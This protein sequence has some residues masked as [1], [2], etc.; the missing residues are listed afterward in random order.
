MEMNRDTRYVATWIVCFAVLLAALAPFIS[1][2]LSATK[3]ADDLWVQVC[4]VKGSRLIKVE[5]EQSS[6]SSAPAKSIPTE[7]CPFC[8]THAGAVGLPP[9]A[10]F[11]LPLLNGTPMRPVLYYQSPRPLFVW[12]APQSRAPPSLS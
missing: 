11:H 2:A 5:G 9:A 1:F 7:H 6:T 10:E 12:A 3:G 4:S 8:F